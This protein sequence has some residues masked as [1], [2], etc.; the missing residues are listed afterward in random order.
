MLE[1]GPVMHVAPRQARGS[2]DARCLGL[3]LI[4]AEHLQT[5][6]TTEQKQDRMNITPKHVLV[7][8]ESIQQIVHVPYA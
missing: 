2:H 4:H 6:H 5:G 1:C 8:P 7:F 3:V